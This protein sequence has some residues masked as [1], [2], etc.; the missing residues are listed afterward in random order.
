MLAAFLERVFHWAPVS[1]DE[2]KLHG[3]VENLLSR[4]NKKII[5]LSLS[6]LKPIGN[7]FSELHP[8]LHFY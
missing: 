8:A 2:I 5:I 4:L 3:T 7:A 1:Q 6:L